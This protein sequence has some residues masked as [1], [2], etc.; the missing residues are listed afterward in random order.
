[1]KEKGTMILRII[2]GSG[3]ADYVAKKLILV[4]GCTVYLKK[5]TVLMNHWKIHALYYGE[6]TILKGVL[7]AGMDPDLEMAIPYTGFLLQNGKENVLVD[8]GVADE[9]LSKIVISGKPS[10]GGR[11]Y[12]LDALKKQGLTP[13]DINTVIYTHLNNDHAGCPELFPDATAII[14]FDEYQN[15]LNPSSEQQELLDYDVDSIE[16]LHAVKN[17][18]FVNGDVVLDNGLE[19]YKVPGHTKG[20][21]AIVVPTAEGRYVLV[22]DTPHLVCCIFPKMDE[23]QLMDGSYVNITPAPDSMLPFLLNS[24][25]YDKQ[26]GFNSFKKLVNLGENFEPK[27][28]LT[29]HDPG[30]IFIGTFG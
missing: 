28:Y 6:L 27:Y 21:Q 2:S 7:S 12:I 8:T 22:G 15:L 17:I 1:M 14:Q 11:N 30:N 5:G 25:I 26:E 18:N 4:C 16:R 20:S 3:V 13:S 29:S 9:F 10:Y 23:M 19:L 24:L